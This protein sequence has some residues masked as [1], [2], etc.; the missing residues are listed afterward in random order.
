MPTHT[1]NGEEITAKEI[2]EELNIPYPT[3]NHYTNLGLFSIV[4]KRGN[5]RVYDRHE[6]ENRYRTISRLADE[7]YPLTLIRKKICAPDGLSRSLKEISNEG[8][9]NGE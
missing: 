8:G 3:I 4:G 6:V 1:N 2:C 5:R 7:G 9:R